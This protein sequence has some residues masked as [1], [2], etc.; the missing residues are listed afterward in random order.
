MPEADFREDMEAATGVFESPPLLVSYQYAV[1][2][3]KKF[4]TIEILTI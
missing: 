3:D 1:K 4:K 2:F